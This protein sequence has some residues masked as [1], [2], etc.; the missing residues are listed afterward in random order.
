MGVF[1]RAFDIVKTASE[2]QDIP[3]ASSE[4]NEWSS[5]FKLYDMACEAARK[6]YYAISGETISEGDVMT[7]QHRGLVEKQL[8]AMKQL[9]FSNWESSK[10]VAYTKIFPSVEARSLAQDV[11]ALVDVGG[12]ILSGR[13]YEE[14]YPPHEQL[15]YTMPDFDQQDKAQETSLKL[16][17]RK[18][19]LDLLIQYEGISP[20]SDKKATQGR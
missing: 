13:S 9:A 10:D 2:Q 5:A 18:D 20:D 17:M 15:G 6:K 3:I 16:S 7:S 12:N 1:A 8:T 4:D 19:E 14:Q 11:L